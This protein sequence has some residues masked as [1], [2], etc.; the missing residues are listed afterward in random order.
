MVCRARHRSGSCGGTEHQV[1]RLAYSSRGDTAED[2]GRLRDKAE[3]GHSWVWGMRRAHPGLGLRVRHLGARKRVRQEQRVWGQAHGRLGWTEVEAPGTFGRWRS[4]GGQQ[5]GLG[6][7]EYQG[8]SVTGVGGMQEAART[9][10]HP[11]ES[12]LHHL[13]GELSASG[14]QGQATPAQLCTPMPCH[15]DLHECGNRDDTHLK[16]TPRGSRRYREG[17]KVTVT[18]PVLL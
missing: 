16:Y 15:Y 9:A 5:R 7:R 1:W 10:S 4:K 14:R 18:G 17:E 2:E 8:R 3:L 6:S 13:P 11:L 12:C